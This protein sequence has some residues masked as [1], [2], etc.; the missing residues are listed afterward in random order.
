V[1]PPTKP[2]PKHRKSSAVANCTLDGQ[3]DIMTASAFVPRLMSID[4]CSNHDPDAPH[5]TPDGPA[6]IRFSRC[7]KLGINSASPLNSMAPKLYER[8]DERLY[9]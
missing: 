6:S 8:L 7:P 4:T 3:I 9:K 5:L 1:Y 2:A